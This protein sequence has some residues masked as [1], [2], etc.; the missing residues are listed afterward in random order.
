MINSAQDLS[1][2]DCR[3]MPALSSLTQL[4][5]LIM[6][7][8]SPQD[9]ESFT[10]HEMPQLTSLVTDISSVAAFNEMT[11]LRHLKA[12]DVRGE[13]ICKLFIFWVLFFLTIK[14]EFIRVTQR[15]PNLSSFE[16]G[17]LQE[18]GG[19]I[20][21]ATRAIARTLPNIKVHLIFFFQIS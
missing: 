9:P 10:D 16:L 13:F 12:L 3:I 8:H 6:V 2:T 5:T 14:A 19:T 21:L 18:S 1:H 4:K 15:F 17:G 7:H 20:S 11:S